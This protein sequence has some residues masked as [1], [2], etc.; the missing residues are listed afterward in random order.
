MSNRQ[1]ARLKTDRPRDVLFRKACQAGCFIGSIGDYEQLAGIDIQSESERRALWW[2]FE[3]LFRGQS[4][5]LIDAVVD[6]CSQM[7]LDAI[8]GG[9]LCLLGRTPRVLQSE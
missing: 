7:A 2:K 4:Q 6:H 9:R 3:P 1:K 8:E 5:P